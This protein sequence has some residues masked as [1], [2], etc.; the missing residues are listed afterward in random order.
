MASSMDYIDIGDLAKNAGVILK[1]ISVLQRI[2]LAVAHQV[3]I[4]LVASQC[5]TL[6]S[7]ATEPK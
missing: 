5:H 4:T 2:F 7:M 6:V 1:L 3:Q